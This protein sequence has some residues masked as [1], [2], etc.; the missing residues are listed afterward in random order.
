MREDKAHWPRCLLWH[1]WLPMLSGVNG[2]IPWAIDASG[3]ALYLVEVARGRYSSGL[4]AECG[5]PHDF[6]ADDVAARMPDTPEIWSD[7]SLVLDSVAGVSVAGAGMFAHQ[8]ELCWSD[9][10]WGHFDRVQSGDVAHSCRG[11][12]SVPGPLQT[13]QRAELWGGVILALQSSDAVHV[14]VDNL[15]VVRHV[16]RLLDDCFS[17]VLK[18]LFLMVICSFLFAGCLIFVAVTR[19][20]LLGSRVMLMRAWFEMVGFVSLTGLATMLPM[21]LLTFGAGGGGPCCY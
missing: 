10:R 5:L 16:G 21:R 18:S 17:A 4:V 20:L 19:F 15:G 13:A 8:S 3:S 7:G 9:R 6:D 11:F 1:G 12:V 14:G 2:A